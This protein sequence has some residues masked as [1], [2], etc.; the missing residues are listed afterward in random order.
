MSYCS[1]LQKKDSST[2]YDPMYNSTVL[3]TLTGFPV[4]P[5]SPIPPFIPGRP[6]SPGSPYYV[7]VYTTYITISLLIGLPLNKDTNRTNNCIKRGQVL[8]CQWLIPMCQLFRWFYYLANSH[9]FQVFR[10]F[11]EDLPLLVGQLVPRNTC[12]QVITIKFT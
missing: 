2:L 11:L 4:R 9:L 1:I 3:V 6:G 7:Y 8:Y 10:P 5:V 12:N